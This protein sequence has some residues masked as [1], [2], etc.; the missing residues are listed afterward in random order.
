MNKIN[1]YKQQ[2]LKLKANIA[3]KISKKLPSADEILEEIEQNRNHSWI[4][5]TVRDDRLFAEAITDLEN[6]M[7]KEEFKSTAFLNKI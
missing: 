1:E 5:E 2:L 4:R 3:S 6:G 7:T